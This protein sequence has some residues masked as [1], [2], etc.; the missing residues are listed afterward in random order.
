MQIKLRARQLGPGGIAVTLKPYFGRGASQ[1]G[2]ADR[3]FGSTPPIIVSSIG[4]C[5]ILTAVAT[6]W[7]VRPVGSEPFTLSNSQMSRIT[8]GGVQSDAL[9][10][11]TGRGL[12]PYTR[13]DATATIDPRTGTAKAAADGRGPEGSD[14]IVS[15][16]VDGG[17][18]VLTTDAEADGSSSDGRPTSIRADGA[19]SASQSQYRGGSSSTSRA[20]SGSTRSTTILDAEDGR[21]GSTATADGASVREGFTESATEVEAFVRG[22]TI[23][24]RTGARAS[25]D[26]ADA[27]SVD[28]NILVERLGSVIEVVSEAG[29]TS[30]R[31]SS[32]EMR[33]VVIQTATGTIVRSMARSASGRGVG[34][35]S[36]GI[37][38]R[39]PGGDPISANRAI[40]R[41]G[42]A[43][44][45]ST[46]VIPAE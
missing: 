43:R 39:V 3:H 31:G 29:S 44:A 40:I 10:D 28:G 26:G 34:N 24:H 8:A 9:A 37:S 1:L 5:L 32:A 35:P 2:R 19:G 20:P 15:V 33:H 21:M 14:G 23:A 17:D 42:E 36:A 11:A 38:V 25:G 30:R 27:A 46:M 7:S 4:I 45:T 41:G 12:S 16:S 18:G 6:A 13:S 22:N